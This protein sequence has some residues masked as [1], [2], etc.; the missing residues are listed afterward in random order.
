MFFKR[1]SESNILDVKDLFDENGNLR[2]LQ[3]LSCILN[4]ETNLLGDNKVMKST[5]Q[6]LYK[7]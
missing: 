1:W 4:D 3:Q 7:V 2:S 5:K 6:I